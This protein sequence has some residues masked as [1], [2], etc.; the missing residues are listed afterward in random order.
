MLVHKQLNVQNDPGC[1]VKYDCHYQDLKDYARQA[2]EVTYGDAHK[3]RQ[4]EG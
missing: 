3:Q 1:F 4:G 2:G